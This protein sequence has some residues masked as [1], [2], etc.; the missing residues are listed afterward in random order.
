MSGRAGNFVFQRGPKG[1]TIT[2][3]YQPLV[4]NPRTTG[5]MLQRSKVALC[6]QLSSIVP[7]DLLVGMG[8]TKAENR[9]MFQ[10]RNLAHSTSV[11]SDDKYTASLPA[12]YI[13]FSHGSVQPRARMQRGAFTVGINNVTAYITMDDPAALGD[14]GERL[15]ALT[16]AADGAYKALGYVDW[17]PTAV[18]PVSVDIPMYGV[19]FANGDKVVCYRIPFLLS[20][21]ARTSIT[22]KNLTSAADGSNYTIVCDIDT[23]TSASTIAYGDTIYSGMTELAVVNYIVEDVEEHCKLTIDGEPA[24]EGTHAAM[25][26]T[27]Q[28]LVWEDIESSYSFLI[29]RRSLAT[30]AQ[31]ETLTTA[32]ADGGRTLTLEAGFEYKY[33][34]R[35]M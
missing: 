3:T 4:A 22:V 31:F 9:L 6:G 20:A 7:A 28:Q 33:T 34:T 14:Y 10:K 23:A 26:G 29:Q 21:G 5:Q 30:G 15:V 24:E 19:P 32:T 18:G 25:A 2:R 35:S 8:G 13:M 16:I 12:E 11:F 17:M 27:T 1:T